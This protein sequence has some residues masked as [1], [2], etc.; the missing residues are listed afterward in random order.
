MKKNVRDHALGITFPGAKKILL[1]MKLTLFIILFSILAAKATDVYSQTTRLS[2]DVKNTSVRDVLNAIENRSE[3]FFLYSEKIIDVNRKVNIDVQNGTIEKILDQVFVGTNVSYTLKG[4]QIVLTTPAANNFYGDASNQ[5]QNTVT[6]KVVDSTGSSLPGVSVVIK[7]TTNGTITDTDGNFKIQSVPSNAT[8]QFSFVG[9]KTQEVVVGNKTSIDVKLVDETI[10]LEE[11]VA[12]G[13]GV[14][15][16]SNITGSISSVK[17]EDI[18]SRSNTSLVD[19]MA[20]KT[21]GVTIV[22]TSGAPGAAGTMLI[23]GYSSNKSSYPLYV[24]DGLRVNSIS[25]LD[26]K[27]IES[28]EILKDAASAAIY[29]AEA[30][31]GVV[32]I[33]T[34]KGSAGNSQISY[35][36][37]YT[38]NDMVRTPV[39]LNSKEYTDWLILNGKYTQNDINATVTAGLWDGKSSTDWMHEMT[40]QGI[41]PRHT[42]SLQGGSEKGNYYI[43]L[44]STNQ[45]G[46]VVGKYDTYKRVNGTLNVSYKFRPWLEVGNN[47]NYMNN[48]TNAVTGGTGLNDS[49]FGYI[50]YFD[51]TVSVTYSPDKLPTYMKSYLSSGKTLL[52]DENGNYYGISQLISTNPCNPWAKLRSTDKENKTDMI[53]G[54][55]YANISPIKGLVY[56]SRLGYNLN[57]NNTWNLNRVYYGGPSDYANDASVSRS[58]T[59]STYY[60]WENFINYNF[61]LLGVH[62][63]TTMLGMS[64]SQNDV[65]YMYGIESKLRKDVQDNPLFWDL[66]YKASDSNDD[67]TATHNWQR[68]LSYYGRLNYSYRDLYSL[69]LTMRADAADLSILSL[70]NRWGYFPA[71][72]AGWQMS[73]E[74]WFKAINFIDYMKA[75]ASWGQNG[76]TS[77]LTDYAYSNFISTNALG[78]SL[79]GSTYSVSATTSGLSNDLL[80][81]ETSEQLD[82]GVDLRFLKSRLSFS[83][84]WYKKTTKGL[85]LTSGITVPASAGASAPVMNSGNVINQG[86]EF[87]AGWK[88][89]IGK[90]NYSINANFSTL[91]NEVKSVHSTVKR[92]TDNALQSY[93]NLTAFEVGHPVWYIWTYHCEGIN[94]ETGNPIITDTDGNGVIN[95][96]DKIE[97]GSGLPD[98][99][100]GLTLSAS[101][102]NFSCTVF[103]QG[104][105]GN[106]IFRA[107]GPYQ[108]NT[109]KYFYDRTWTPATKQ[110]ATRAP[111]NTGNYQ[112]YIVSD[113]FVFDADY[114][115]IKQIQ[116]GYTLPSSIAKKALL[117][118]VKLYVSLEDWFTF[119]PYKV[120]MD[121]SVSANNSTGIGI[122]YG[123]Y[124]NYK[125][126]VFGINVSF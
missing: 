88:D 84:D 10:G 82:F 63:F 90:L 121:P 28:M 100:Y 56:T 113:A 25:D 120:G 94:P 112:Y 124:P 35:E 43:S 20:G 31:N 30:G 5:Q 44:G 70:K 22:S 40:E 53:S 62:D 106:Q 11:V 8:L 85:I 29:G 65:Y 108:Q 95:V 105:G 54:S 47:T 71:I 83:A 74:S 2:M 39:S 102:K 118:N 26:P 104:V 116:F 107:T 93:G 46:I 37:Q 6:G 76:S 111:M 91:H 66:A 69:Q 77:S 34:K 114:F 24:V 38:I 16:K 126:T 1:K 109:I 27:T 52:T 4:R 50:Y 18:A 60:Q 103:G 80:K 81:W 73:N 33:T 99:Q 98:Y 68:K 55:A 59:K 110:T 48:S 9:M 32:L 45:D 115:K 67:V 122:D 15:K 75:R 3:F 57:V 89:K 86:F 12:V 79:D 19:A 14:Q 42:L 64:Y 72:S 49:F 92:Y 7:G 117:Q 36:F 101:Y 123:S 61:K 119:T 51:P 41:S 125:K 78:Y 13:Y 97:A 21:S 23:R 17:T 96:E 58:L 87:E